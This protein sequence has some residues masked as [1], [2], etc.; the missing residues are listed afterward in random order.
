MESVGNLTSPEDAR[1]VVEIE[2]SGDKMAEHFTH[3]AKRK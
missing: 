3:I 2:Q 1:F